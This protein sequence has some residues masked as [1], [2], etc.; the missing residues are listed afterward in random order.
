MKEGGRGCLQTATTAATELTVWKGREDKDGNG[1]NNE[2]KKEKRKSKKGGEG[3]DET[4][5]EEGA[6]ET[7][8]P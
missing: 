4:H 6:G 8:K 2:R 5:D 3:G 1:N 7:K